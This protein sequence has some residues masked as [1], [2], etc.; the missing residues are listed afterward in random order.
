MYYKPKTTLVGSKVSLTLRH[1]I[2]FLFS[3][4]LEI[5]VIALI[6]ILLLSKV[7][8]SKYNK[9]SFRK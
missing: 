9:W 5:D 4:V 8:L 1:S 2:V 7:E 3:A 6:K